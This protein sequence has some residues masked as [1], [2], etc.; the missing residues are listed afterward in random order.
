[1]GGNGCAHGTET[2]YACL[3][4]VEDNSQA[5]ESHPHRILR[6]AAADE[7]GRRPRR[8]LRD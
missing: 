1:M 5:Q 2:V 8:Q 3:G 4:F 7:R 6:R